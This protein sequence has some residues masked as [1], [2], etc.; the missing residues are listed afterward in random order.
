MHFFNCDALEPFGARET[1]A[2]PV[3]LG[4]DWPG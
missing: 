2:Q 4:K 3:K 1:R